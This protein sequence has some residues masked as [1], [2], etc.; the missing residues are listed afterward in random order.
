[1]STHALLHVSAFSLSQVTSQRLFSVEYAVKLLKKLADDGNF[2]LGKVVHALL[3]VSS[4]ASEDHIIQ[5]N[6]LINLYSRCGQLAVARRVFDRLS[7]RNVVSWSILMAGYLHNGY[8]WEVTN[9]FKDM[10]SVDKIF[11]NEYVLSTVLS[12]CSSGRLLHEGQQCHALVLKS[13]LVFH[14]YVKNA[15]LSL[16]TMSSDMEGVLETLKSVPGLD[17][18]TYN[19]VL[20]GFLDHGYTSEALDVFSRMLADGSAGDSVSYVNIFGLCARLKDLKLGKQ[21]HCRMLKS[22]LQLDVFLSSAIMDMYGKCGEISG[23]RYIF[24]SYPNHNVVSWT[25]ILAAN[26]Q[27]ECFEEALKLFLRMEFQ[28]V[29]PNEYT[30]AV[31]LN[32]C[33]GLSALG[34]GKTLHARV[35]KTGHGAFVVVGNALINMYFRSGHIEAAR[36]LFSNMISRDT[37]TWN[38][39]ISGFSHHGLGEEALFVF[40]HMLAAEEKPNYVTFVGVLLACG[41]L[42]R[43]EEGFYYLQHLMRDIG[44][45]PG[46]EHYTCVVGLLGKAGKLDEAEN[47]MRSTPITWDVVAWR[48]L[49]NACNV[50]RNYDLG[51]RV[52]EH[53]LQLNPNDVGTYILL[54]NMHAKVKRWDGVAKIRKLLRERNIKKEPGLSWTEIRNET[55]V[56]V[57]D[58]T[59]HPETAQIHEKVRKLLADIKPLGYVPDTASVLHDVEQEQ[60][61][62]YLSYHSEKLAVAYALMK[63]P[64]QAPIHVIKNLRICDDC[65]SA[66]KLISKVAM[67]M[68]VVRDVNRFHT[69]QDGS[70]SCANYW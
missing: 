69:F 4:H 25:A 37:V 5:N 12:S 22:G 64:S 24:D 58:D 43:I 60:Q 18:I 1:M 56:F 49:L 14:Q 21:V 30:F 36:A 41:H 6:C 40:Q 70:C 35:E 20:K 63:T 46:L 57:S 3:V 52:A 68:I 44:L 16:Y 34:C 17:M 10:I 11:P 29:V 13:G 54:S 39:T 55:H 7:Q 27:N 38:M 15:L 67:R 66:L 9:L 59:Q 19:S 42:G 45:E 61:E 28:D 23:A 31:L 33:A 2:K 53:L 47:F 51:K 26:F 65:H 48:T 8:A 32:S 50:H 62:D